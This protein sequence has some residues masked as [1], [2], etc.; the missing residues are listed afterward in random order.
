MKTVFFLALSLLTIAANSWGGDKIYTNEDLEQYQQKERP[1]VLVIWQDSIPYD[2]PIRQSERLEPLCT[3]EMKSKFRSIGGEC[4]EMLE[5]GSPYMGGKY[6]SLLK[7]KDIDQGKEDEEILLSISGCPTLQD[8]IIDRR[9]NKGNAVVRLLRHGR[10]LQE[11]CDTVGRGCL[12]CTRL[13]Q[14]K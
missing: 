7:G 13:L 10:T 6:E 14:K 8:S 11:I 12:S 5:G 4:V 1:S 9:G 2:D 3:E